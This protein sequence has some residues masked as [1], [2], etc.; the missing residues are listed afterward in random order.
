MCKRMG[1]VL[2]AVLLLGG[3]WPGS[4]S[5]EFYAGLTYLNEEPVPIV[6]DL[7]GSTVTGSAL[8]QGQALQLTGTLNERRE[9][10]I[11][12]LGAN[13]DVLATL[14]GWEPPFSLFGI[15][16]PA[17]EEAPRWLALTGGVSASGQAFQARGGL[18]RW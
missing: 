10:S 17:V 14:F 9:A 5:A 12:V 4:A 13:G 7:H 8:Y 1:L 18:W 15:L 16:L 6:L 3:G 2:L 11:D